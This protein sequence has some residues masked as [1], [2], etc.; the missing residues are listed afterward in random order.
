[1]FGAMTNRGEGGFN[2]AGGAQTLPV[3]CWKVIK[4]QQLDSVLRQTLASFGVFGL[5]DLDNLIEAL[6]RLEKK[7]L[8]YSK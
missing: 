7:L 2:R 8:Y 6:M 4:Y 3:V 5:T 1:M